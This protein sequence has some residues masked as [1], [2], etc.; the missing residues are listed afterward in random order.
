[1]PEVCKIMLESLYC[2]S[3]GILGNY[4]L[5]ITITSNSLLCYTFKSHGTYFPNYDYFA[6]GTVLAK[7]K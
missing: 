7:T 5:L 6:G 2:M 3:N 4:I 1:M